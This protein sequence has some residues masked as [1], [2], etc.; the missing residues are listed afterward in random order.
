MYFWEANSYHLIQ[1][2]EQLFIYIYNKSKMDSLTVQF[3]LKFRQIIFIMRVYTNLYGNQRNVSH[4]CRA[5]MMST[6]Y[7]LS[8]SEWLSKAKGELINR[9]VTRQA[10]NS[11]VWGRGASEATEATC[12]SLW[13]QLFFSYNQIQIR[14]IWKHAGVLYGV[15]C[16]QCLFILKLN[17]TYGKLSS[18]A[19]SDLNN[20]LDITE[21]VHL[22]PSISVRLCTVVMILQHSALV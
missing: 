3:K 5:V 19:F 16:H 21:T 15:I 13:D 4:Q 12:S 14:A 1:F 22:S 11:S 9:C 6:C 2:I 8:K 10:K 7:L 17:Y 20:R 18:N